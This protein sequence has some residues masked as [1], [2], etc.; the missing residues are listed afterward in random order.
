MIGVVTQGKHKKSFGYFDIKQKVSMELENTRFISI[1]L[2]DK[3]PD[4]TIIKF[5]ICLESLN[6]I[7]GYITNEYPSEIMELYKIDD[8]KIKKQFILVLEFSKESVLSGISNMKNVEVEKQIVSK[9]KEHKNKNVAELKSKDK[10]DLNNPEIDYYFI[11]DFEANNNLNSETNKKKV[12]YEIIEFPVLALNAKTLKVDYTFHQYIKPTLMPKLTTEIIDL[13][14]ITQEI[15]DK[16]IELIECLK[17]FDNWLE[18]NNLKNKIFVFVTCGD[19]DLMTCLRQECKSKKIDYKNYFKTWV[20]IKSCFK[21]YVKED[22]L[23]IG[24][25]GMLKRL[26]LTLDGKHH[27]GIDDCKNIAKIAIELLSSKID[28]RKYITNLK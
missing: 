19:W 8:E 28:F 20:N 21:E 11:L 4:S 23:K 17:N 2:E 14:G 26:N 1:F 18:D 15:V 24:M 10:N 5:K 13:T 9:E 6:D 16:G 12:V 22:N 3:L 7:V 25:D 27:S